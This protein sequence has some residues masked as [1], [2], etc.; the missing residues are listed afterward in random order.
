MDQ[1]KAPETQ[2]QISSLFLPKLYGSLEKN[3][4]IWRR[5]QKS[6]RK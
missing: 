4:S 3:L 1:K 6:N 5:K 2:P